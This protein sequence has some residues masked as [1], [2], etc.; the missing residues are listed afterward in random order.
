M[1]SHIVIFNYNKSGLVD[2]Y[3]IP[4]ISI[5]LFCW[6]NHKKMNYKKTINY[7]KSIGYNKCVADHIIL[8]W[9][10]EKYHHYQDKKEEICTNIQENW[11]LFMEWYGTIKYDLKPL[12]RQLV[13]QQHPLKKLKE[14]FMEKL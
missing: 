7:L 12:R 4:C 6:K 8:R 10:N 14:E 3:N 5:L 2:N 13:K 9:N 1:F 11:K